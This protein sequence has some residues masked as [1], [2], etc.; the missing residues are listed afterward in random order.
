MG[1]LASGPSVRVTV[2]QSAPRIEDVDGNLA[3]CIGH[4][5]RAAATSTDLVVFPECSLS[6]Y[7][8]D[9]EQAARRCADAIPG[10]ITDALGQTCERMG[11]HCVVGMLEIEGPALYN[12]AVLMSPQGIVGRYRKSHIACLGV[13][14]FTAPGDEPYQVFDTPVGRIGVEI[15]Y[16]WRFPEITRVLALQGAEIIVHPTNSPVQARELAEFITRARAAENAVFFVTANRCGKERGTEF[17]GWS[18]IIDPQGRRMAEAG[19]DESVLMADL[20]LRLAREK[21]REPQQG[22]YHVRLFQDRRPDLYSP[23]AKDE[24]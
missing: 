15:C 23:L 16:D 3:A 11:L 6:G 13:D 12:T 21:T 4:L 5:E 14:R 24:S 22:G 7:M 2:V 18:Q 1:E 10:R 20:D 17:F 8:L 19:S 9:D